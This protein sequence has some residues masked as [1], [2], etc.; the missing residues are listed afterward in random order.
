MN[1]D[2]VG[3][4]TKLGAELADGLTN[5]ACLLIELFIISMRMNHI[6]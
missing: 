3:F 5:P 4:Y 2:T 1:D 6:V